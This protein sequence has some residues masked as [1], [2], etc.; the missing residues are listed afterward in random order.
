MVRSLSLISSAISAGARRRSPPWLKSL[1][2]VGEYIYSHGQIYTRAYTSRGNL[3]G[4]YPAPPPFGADM[5]IILI[6]LA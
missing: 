5:V 4:T 2:R 1:P 3:R 6:P